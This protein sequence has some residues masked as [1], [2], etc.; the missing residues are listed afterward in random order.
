MAVREGCNVRISSCNAALNPFDWSSEVN[1]LLPLIQIGCGS[2]QIGSIWMCPV[3]R[4]LF[5]GE[6][7]ESL[8]AEQALVEAEVNGLCLRSFIYA[9]VIC[10]KSFWRHRRELLTFIKFFIPRVVFAAVSG[11]D[12]TV[13]IGI[14]HS[15][16]H[17]RNSQWIELG[18]SWVASVHSSINLVCISLSYSTFGEIIL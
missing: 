9:T 1:S 10:A 4:L 16:I 7:L 17:L 18:I 12:R 5:S 11:L 13:R 14:I 6:P 2:I 3:C 15:I 8:P